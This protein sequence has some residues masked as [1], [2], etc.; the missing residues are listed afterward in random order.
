MLRIDHAFRDTI[1]I[2]LERSVTGLRRLSSLPLAA[3]LLSGCYLSHGRGGLD[4]SSDG[5]PGDSG[6]R[7][8]GPRDSG[9]RDAGPLDCTVT[10]SLPPRECEPAPV[11]CAS[12]TPGCAPCAAGI[13][14]LRFA[15]DALSASLAVDGERAAL[16][17]IRVDPSGAGSTVF[18]AHVEGD[19][20]VG[21]I[22]SCFDHRAP[23][24]VALARATGGWVMAVE[25]DRALAVHLL[26]DNGNDR[27]P[28]MRIEDAV[29]PVLADRPVG[30]PL[31]VWTG[32]RGLMAAL[33]ADGCTPGSAP[34]ELIRD[35]V[36]P[37]FADAA[38]IGDAFLAIC[39]SAGVTVARVGL[40]GLMEGPV[41]MPATG[42]TET[43]SIASSGGEILAGY[44]EFGASPSGVQL[45][46]LGPDG[47]ALAPPSSL[48]TCRSSS[49]PHRSPTSAA[50][51]G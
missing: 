25:E 50:R 35:P 20:S 19:L 33:V 41:V 45:L 13:A 1:R 27:G 14:C 40:D 26:D 30:G 49:T 37:R 34:V 47:R 48:G 12:G 22:G 9:R 23:Q 36:E 43:P 46:R 51:R 6:P 5:G 28:P 29:A 44:S 4:A 10:P 16:A 21:P 2:A 11:S 38:F 31:L 3:L 17:W 42:S 8:G 24:E 18:F 15:G 7:D 32:S 39:R